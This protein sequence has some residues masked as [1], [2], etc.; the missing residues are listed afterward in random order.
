MNDTPSDIRRLQFE[1]MRN[2]S[3]HRRIELA[4]EMFQT[5]REMIVASLPAGLSEQE[6]KRRLYFRTYGE[7]L[8]EDFFEKTPAA[9]D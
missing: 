6:F 8:P 3:P 1:M 2:L 5:A 9:D 7:P 4:C